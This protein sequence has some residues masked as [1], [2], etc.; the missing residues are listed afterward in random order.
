MEQI[1]AVS[2]TSKALLVVGAA[3]LLTACGLLL[4]NRLIR[5]AEVTTVT[6]PGAPRSARGG[7][8]KAEPGGR[9][10]PRPLPAYGPVPAFSFIDQDRAPLT[11]E[12]LRGHVWLADF[13]FTTCPGQCLLM[14]DRFAA[15]QRALPES[16]LR[17]ISFSVDPA[18]DTPEVLAAYAARY[19]SDPRWRLA[20]GDVEAIRRLSQEGFKLSAV[21]DPASG[22]AHSIRL[23]LVDAH[24]AIRGYYDAGDAAAMARLRR[25]AARLLEGGV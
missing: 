13:I 25:D 2:R 17:F 21:Q 3:V 22:I 19:G 1:R 23:V 15:L 12:S 7:D 18:R 9:A 5:L 8:R 11:D 4:V 14:T 20:T 6:E 24:G 10:R 16:S